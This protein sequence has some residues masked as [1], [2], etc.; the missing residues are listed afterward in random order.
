[1]GT[2]LAQNAPVS[3]HTGTK[4]AQNVPKRLK[5]RC[6]GTK[7]VQNVPVSTRLGT[8]LAQNM[9]KRRKYRCLGTKLAQNVP[10][11]TRLAQNWPKTCPNECPNCQSGALALNIYSLASSSKYNIDLNVIPLLRLRPISQVR[12]VA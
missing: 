6:S 11:S 1:M 5:Y 2:K 7:M 10:V 8:K 12:L 3:N 4:L 9:P